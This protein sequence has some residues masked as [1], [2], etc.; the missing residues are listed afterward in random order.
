METCKWLTNSKSCISKVLLP[1]M[2]FLLRTISKHMRKP[3]Y[4]WG[5]VILIVKSENGKDMVLAYFSRVC[6]VGNRLRRDNMSMIYS[7]QKCE[8]CDFPREGGPFRAKASLS[9]EWLEPS[10]ILYGFKSLPVIHI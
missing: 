3:F 2:K 5:R 7:G 9:S 4:L 10:N 6:E 1:S 8:K